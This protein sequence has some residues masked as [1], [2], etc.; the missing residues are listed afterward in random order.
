MANSVCIFIAYSNLELQMGDTDQPLK[1]IYG[2]KK[3]LSQHSATSSAVGREA[4]LPALYLWR[5]VF[6]PPAA[7]QNVRICWPC[8]TEGNALSVNLLHHLCNIQNLWVEVYSV[9]CGLG[10]RVAEVMNMLYCTVLCKLVVSLSNAKMLCAC[11][12]LIGV[13][14]R[15]T[16]HKCSSILQFMFLCCAN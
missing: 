11:A 6:F 8:T 15:Y 16:H 13:S 3:L 14:N 4:E 5:N 10:H 2:W 9:N 1:L 12:D 7:E